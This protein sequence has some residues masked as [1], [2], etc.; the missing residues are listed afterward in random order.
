MRVAMISSTRA[1]GLRDRPLLDIRHDIGAKVR[2]IG[3]GDG[4]AWRGHV[5]S[6]E[7]GHRTD[8]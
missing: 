5:Q 3:T 4:V 8:R 2:R 7:S 6:G 1:S